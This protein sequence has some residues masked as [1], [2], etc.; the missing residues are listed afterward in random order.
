ML[1]GLRCRYL[2]AADASA[3]VPEQEL[4]RV[5]ELSPTDA[6][7]IVEYRAHEGQFRALEDLRKVPG[8]DFRRIEGRTDRFV[9]AA[10]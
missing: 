10:K 3:V 6:A 9:L 1:L 4:V 5:V 8:L 7:A 2:T